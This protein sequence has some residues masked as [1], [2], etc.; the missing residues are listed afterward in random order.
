MF[1][2]QISLIRGNSFKKVLHF[3]FSRWNRQI[4]HVV[5][6][7]AVEGQVHYQTFRLRLFLKHTAFV[8]IKLK[9]K[10]KER[11]SKYKKLKMRVGDK[12]LTVFCLT[13][14]TDV[15]QLMLGLCLGNHILS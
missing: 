9:G 13:A 14:I 2:S 6:V 8:H 12:K 5:G 15:P 3:C 11:L 7:G 4:L 1:L 10:R